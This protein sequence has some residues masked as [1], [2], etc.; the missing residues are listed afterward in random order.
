MG[1]SEVL[2]STREELSELV[3]NGA[4]TVYMS[5]NAVDTK[6]NRGTL[7]DYF[8][9]EGIDCDELKPLCY[10]D[11]YTWV[12]QFLAPVVGID[13]RDRWKWAEVNR[14]ANFLESVLMANRMQAHVVDQEA[15]G[16]AGALRN[17]AAIRENVTDEASRRTLDRLERCVREYA[18]EGLLR[19]RATSPLGYDELRLIIK[20]P[21]YRAL[22]AEYRS[23][24]M[25]SHTRNVIRSINQR[26][27]EFASNSRA[28]SIVRLTGI[29]VSVVSSAF[30]PFASIIELLLDAVGQPGELQF[31]PMFISS[32]RIGK[33]QAN[34]AGMDM[35]S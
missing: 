2:R 31:V 19:F 21:D 27:T 7:R 29:G 14:L 3:R 11:E 35:L 18:Q 20:T 17:I 30:S 28:R 23:L 26:V 24:G 4:Q 9:A 10:G 12:R 34:V 33:F 15:F 25:S 22:A 1:H 32:A 16:P 5:F 6:A 13:P 8:D